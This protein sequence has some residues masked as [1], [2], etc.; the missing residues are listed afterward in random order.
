MKKYMLIVSIVSACQIYGSSVDSTSL[1][2]SSISSTTEVTSSEQ[3]AFHDAVVAGDAERIKKLVDDNDGHK[4]INTFHDYMGISFTPLGLAV[5]LG[6]NDCFKALLDGGANHKL[7]WKDGSTP[8]HIAAMKGNIVCGE[9]LLDKDEKFSD[10]N[11]SCETPLNVAVIA[12]HAAF[13]K[14]LIERGVHERGRSRA[15]STQ[16]YPYAHLVFNQNDDP[17]KLVLDAITSEH[18]ECLEVLLD[19][20]FPMMREFGGFPT[21][22]LMAARTGN[23][24][25]LRDLLLRRSPYLLNH[26]D[27]QE[28]ATALDVAASFGHTKCIELLLEAGGLLLNSTWIGENALHRAVKNNH[29]SCVTLL[30]KAFPHAKFEIAS[31]TGRSPL[32]EAIYRGN[33]RCIEILLPQSDA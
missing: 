5:Y 17:M 12:G 23:D 19:A 8:L 31:A 9:L 18:R 15:S 27:K 6:K 25:I 21:S 3:F 24:A 20:R 29:V 4:S 30:N 13:V 7:G 11:E 33:T 16:E 32:M 28:G 10:D 22:L 26:R 14:L 2:D 1:L